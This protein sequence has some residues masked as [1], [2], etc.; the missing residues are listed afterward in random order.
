MLDQGWLARLDVRP[1]SDHDFETV[2]R[3]GRPA[4][5][6][7]L[8]FGRSAYGLL[9]LSGAAALLPGQELLD[10][11]PRIA[12]LAV[13]ARKLPEDAAAATRALLL[14]FRASPGQAARLEELLVDAQASVEREPGTAAWFAL[15]F[16]DGDHGLFAAFPD[17]AARFAHLAGAVPRQLAQRA[18]AVLAGVPDMDLLQVVAAR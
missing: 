5:S 17:D 11:P 8:R 16:A 1:G 18:L 7:A 6:F 13:L 10:G 9:D 12:P 3:E 15:R 14:T 4:G 2:L